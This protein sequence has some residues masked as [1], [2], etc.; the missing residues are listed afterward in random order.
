M[1]VPQRL[2]GGLGHGVLPGHQRSAWGWR[3]T[4]GP[5]LGLRIVASTAFLLFVWGGLSVWGLGYPLPTAIRGMAECSTPWCIGARWDRRESPS[6]RKCEAPITGRTPCSPTADS[7]DRPI[8]K[9]PQFTGAQTQKR[10]TCASKASLIRKALPTRYYVPTLSS[11]V[12]AKTQFCPLLRC[13][14]HVSY[15]EPLSHRGR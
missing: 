9:F 4:W 15:V 6:V 3:Q 8:E 2:S 5:S 12:G 11:E 1:E 10:G 14:E 7:F 13:L